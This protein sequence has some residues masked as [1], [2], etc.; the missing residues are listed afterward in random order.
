M[1]VPPASVDKESEPPPPQSHS[2]IQMTC[3]FQI[4]T[5]V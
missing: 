2:L 1:T 5:G 4:F 3:Q